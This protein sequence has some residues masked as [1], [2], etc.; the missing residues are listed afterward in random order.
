[1]PISFRY[2]YIFIRI[3]LALVF[4]WF[5]LN[6]F[7]DPQTVADSLP[8]FLT[9][10]ASTMHLQLRDIVFLGGIIELVIALSLVT[11]YFIR[12]FAGAA[13]IFVI[14]AV[15]VAHGHGEVI[16]WDISL[17]GI[18]AAIVAW[19]ERNYF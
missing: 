9:A 13:A 15:L 17:F 2:P 12:W 5:G 3:S 6:K 1:M 16:V 14:L 10:I 19:P 7:I 4:F 11:G 8:H 18:L